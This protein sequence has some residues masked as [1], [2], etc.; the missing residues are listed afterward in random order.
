AIAV[1]AN[2]K[3]PNETTTDH[4]EE[5]VVKTIELSDT[6]KQLDINVLAC[7]LTDLITEGEFTGENGT[8]VSGRVGVDYA[9]RKVILIGLGDPAK[10]K[11]YEWRKAAATA[12]KL[13]NKEKDTS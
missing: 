3:D 6:I 2:P 13:S 5:K 8:S 11:V 7:T 9:V 4:A 12:L 10:S 1:F